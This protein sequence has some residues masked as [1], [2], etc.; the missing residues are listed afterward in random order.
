MEFDGIGD[1]GDELQGWC[2]ADW[3]GDHRS[4]TI[5][6]FLYYGGTISWQSK[7]QPTIALSTIDAKYMTASH[8]SKEAIWLCQVHDDLGRPCR[9]PT[10]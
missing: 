2:D 5:Y 6:A 8:S 7:K 10:P 4:M 3:A 1:D 9:I